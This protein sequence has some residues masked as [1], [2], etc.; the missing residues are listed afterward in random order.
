MR[1]A[2]FL[3]ALPV[4]LAGCQVGPAYKHPDTPTPI[5]WS[6]TMSKGEAWPTSGWWTAF[7][8]PQL[9]DLIQR[10]Q[11]NNNDLAAAA[12]RIKEADAQARIA[13]AALLPS[14]GFDANA[15]PSREL[16][17]TGQE[18]HHVDM[19]GVLQASYQL[20]FWGKN[21]SALQ[22][23]EASRSAAAYAWQVVN[24]STAAGVATA[25]FQYIGLTERLQVAESDLA[26][27]RSTL[28]GLSNQA[29]SGTVPMLDVVQ[30][31]TIVDGLAAQ[32]P[33]IRQQIEAVH[34]ALAILV[35]A[36][37]ESLDLTPESLS[38]VKE[39]VV[40]AGLP[41]ELLGRRPDVQEA[42]ANLMAANADIRVARAEFFPSFTLTASEGLESYAL[43]HY[44]VP[45]L[46]V[47]SLLGNVSAP[48]FEGGRLRAQLHY[49]QAHYEELLQDYR[50]SA[51]SAFGDVENALT[52]V[53]ETG[54]QHAA[55]L[56]TLQSAR[57]SY[58][59]ALEAFHGGTTTILNVFTAEAAVT[60]A[61]DG[62]SQSH[63]AHMHALISLYQALGG[64]WTKPA[65]TAQ[66]SAAHDTDQASAT[67]TGS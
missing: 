5:A 51:L 43:S 15:G 30:Q 10:A 6:S 42:E 12:A 56:Q 3:T 23:A 38:D 28:S 36:L 2:L 20:D 1:R 59:M 55:Q 11:H 7:G 31:Q 47:Y 54:D 46:N 66:V 40:A 61:E 33:I 53:K 16:N 63:I 62:E 14:V 4:L 24:L 60:A 49:A 41:S 64:G 13:G 18:R 32:P 27:A 48:L 25:Y 65:A 45:P 26:R 21:K 22:A 57:H 17:L 58:Q 19:A 67:R 35:G 8:S 50:K 34:T 39:P 44:T 37:P 9:D 52:A 29:R